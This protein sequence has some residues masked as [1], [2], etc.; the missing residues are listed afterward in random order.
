M[1][2]TTKSKAAAKPTRNG[3]PVKP[4]EKSQ[5]TK[6]LTL[7]DIVEEL[8]IVANVVDNNA[9]AGQTLFDI[10][11]EIIGRTQKDVRNLQKRIEK[12]ERKAGANS[13]KKPSRKRS[14]TVGLPS[15]MAKS[16]KKGK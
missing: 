12:L 10:C 4:E 1:A 7:A 2:K 3:K 14:R 16:S 11:S 6:V 5:P 13:S 15:S 9:N 8:Q